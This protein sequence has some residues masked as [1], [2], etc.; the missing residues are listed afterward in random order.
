MTELALTFEEKASVTTETFINEGFRRHN[1]EQTGLHGRQPSVAF[2]LRD[3]DDLAGAVVVKLFWGQL[4]VIS[5]FVADKWRG[6][7]VAQRLIDRAHDYGRENGCDFSFLE[8][9]SFQAEGFYRKNGYETEMR[10]DGYA[11]GASFLYMKKNLKS[12]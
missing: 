1:F 4:N 7:G 6:Q 2:T 8:T 12:S 11:A 9:L 5:L 3:G 10:R